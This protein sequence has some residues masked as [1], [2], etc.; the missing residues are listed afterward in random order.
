[1]TICLSIEFWAR[2]N[3][4]AE[5]WRHCSEFQVLMWSRGVQSLFFVGNPHF[6]LHNLLG[7]CCCWCLEIPCV[8]HL[9]GLPHPWTPVLYSEHTFPYGSS[10][11]FY[12]PAS[13]SLFSFLEDFSGLLSPSMN[14]FIDMY[15]YYTHIYYTCIYM[16]DIRN[17]IIV[18][19]KI[20]FLK[21]HPFWFW[22]CGQMWFYCPPHPG[23]MVY[24]YMASRFD[25]LTKPETFDSSF[26]TLLQSE[27]K[28]TFSVF[29]YGKKGLPLSPCRH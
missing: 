23:G 28:I 20:Y 3:F 22:E 16:F 24:F 27:R 1:M 25:C 15:I 5:F 4:P 29:Q 8:G 11:R 26:V 2:N 21:Y 13:L 18:I 14:F 17:S 19:E 9:V 7:P 6:P 12:L 10:V